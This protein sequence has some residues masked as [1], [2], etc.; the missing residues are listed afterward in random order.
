MC[1]INAVINGT[2]EDA[3]LMGEATRT[4]G[5]YN[6]YAEVGRIKV[7]FNYLPITD[8]TAP[9][10]PYTFGK[11]KLW[12]NG[13]ISNYRELANK[14][15]L[16]PKSDTD[17]EVLA[18][19]IEKFGYDKLDEL[20]GFFSVL[21]T[22]GRDVRT[23][24]D[25]YGIK[26]LY[27]YVEGGKKYISSE[28]KG[29]LAVANPPV[30]QTAVDDWYYSLGVMTNETIYKGI[31]KSTRLEHKIP[32]EIDI[33]YDEAKDILSVLW[34]RATERNHYSNAGVFL[35]GGVDSGLIAQDLYPRYSF[36]M[37]YTTEHSEIDN[38][39]INSTGEHYT[40]I[41]ND[42]TLNNYLEPTRKALDDLKVGSCYTNYAVSELARKFTKVVYSG[43]GGDEVF[44]GYTHRYNKT[45]EEVVKRT[46]RYTD[47]K[48][49]TK[50][51]THFNYDWA[52]L[53][54]ILIV[55]D[56]MG[57]ANTIETRYP[58]L[59]NDLVDFALSLPE[60]YRYNKRILKDISGLPDEI[61]NGKKRGFSNP[62]DNNTWTELLIK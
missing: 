31:Y 62:V 60:E 51:L 17:T 47:T 39:K 16:E 46:N 25:R 61:V 5:E 45:I 1:G 28:V 18:L 41:H 57:G 4:R 55:E 53:R 30:D 27:N 10:P 21:I 35:S 7:V 37:D 32:M 48:P 14:Y 22:N 24:T 19:F 40:I 34:H 59:D 8:E 33:P 54:G 12:L 44:M 15:A 20:N 56:R 29:I 11:F 42:Q 36:S 43:A 2:K 38:I 13:Y 26:Q 6:V 52:F 23:F 50:G 58:L 49:D 9:P 3:L